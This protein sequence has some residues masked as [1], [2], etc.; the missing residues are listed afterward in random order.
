MHV[1]AAAHPN[2]IGLIS[3][4]RAIATAMQDYTIPIQRYAVQ[5]PPHPN[6]SFLNDWM[7]PFREET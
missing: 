3:G 5:S 1:I 4:I 2:W 6:G 7:R